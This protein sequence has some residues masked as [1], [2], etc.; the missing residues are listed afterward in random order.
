MSNVNDGGKAMSNDDFTAIANTMHLSNLA[1]SAIQASSLLKE[2][3][4][5]EAG[6]D[7]PTA[8]SAGIACLTL[9]LCAQVLTDLENEGVT[10]IPPGLRK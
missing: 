9:E 1:A 2:S 6:E 4:D 5:A 10:Y 3:L 8:V 7:D